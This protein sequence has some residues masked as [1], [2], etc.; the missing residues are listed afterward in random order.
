MGVATFRFN[1]DRSI[2][3]GLFLECGMAVVPVGAALMHRE[4]VDEGLAGRDAGKA[5]SRHAVHRR[6]GDE[7]AGSSYPLNEATAAYRDCGCVIV[8][9]HQRPP[10][11]GVIDWIT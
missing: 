7:R 9:G 8:A 6:C 5:Q 3:S 11:A 1:N 4:A 2:Y 10:P